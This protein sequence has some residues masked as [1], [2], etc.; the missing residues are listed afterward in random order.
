MTDT[1]KDFLVCLSAI[2]AA[3]GFAAVADW[4]AGRDDK[5][6]AVIAGLLALKWLL[7]AGKLAWSFVYEARP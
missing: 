2:G 6:L 3:L 1:V 7:M 5:M 4:A